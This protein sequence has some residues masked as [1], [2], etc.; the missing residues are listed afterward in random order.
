MNKQISTYPLRLPP[1][2]RRELEAR[3][4]HYGRTLRAEILLRLE[5]S[6]AREDA[7]DYATGAEERP[8]RDEVLNLLLHGMTAGLDAFERA[9]DQGASSADMHQRMKQAIIEAIKEDSHD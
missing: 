3:A 9:R 6:I 1:E 2:L 7:A 8:T 4:E 5:E